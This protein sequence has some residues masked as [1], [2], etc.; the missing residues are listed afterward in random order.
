MRVPQVPP[1]KGG[2]GPCAGGAAWWGKWDTGRAVVSA[3]VQW[4]QGEKEKAI[5]SKTCSISHGQKC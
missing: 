3:G 2:R 4:H 1:R 5:K